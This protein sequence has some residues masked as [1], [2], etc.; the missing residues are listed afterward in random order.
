MSITELKAGDKGYVSQIKVD[1][2][3][4]NKMIAI[5]LINGSKFEILKNE[6]NHPVLIF[7]RDTV[8]A[9]NRNDSKNILAEVNYE[10]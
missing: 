8:L 6:K 9:L 7:S 1:T 4:R 2:K 10:Q 5:G 3:F